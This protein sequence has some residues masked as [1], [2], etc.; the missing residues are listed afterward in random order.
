MEIE[1]CFGKIVNIS[2][3][4][5]IQ[6][7]L[8]LI[9]LNNKKIESFVKKGNFIVELKNFDVVIDVKEKLNQINL[10]LCD[11]KWS[12]ELLK[13]LRNSFSF[14]SMVVFLGKITISKKVYEL[15]I[16]A[17]GISSSELVK[18]ILKFK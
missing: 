12:K 6:K 7:A 2:Q 11:K 15:R 16:G 4:K 1:E 10:Y 9:G 5:G 13:S 17:F 3:K 14:K 18:A 8:S